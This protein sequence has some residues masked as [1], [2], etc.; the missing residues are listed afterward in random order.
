MRP[1][2]EIPAGNASQR[3]DPA[4]IARLDMVAIAYGTLLAD[5]TAAGPWPRPW[6]RAL[7]HHGHPQ[8]RWPMEEMESILATKEQRV[9][10]IEPEATVI[11]AVERMCAARV[12]ALLV[13]EGKA[14]LGIFSERDL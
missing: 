8:R 1:Q 6:A 7:L 11:E 13:M 9:H 3:S 5:A 12:G 14:L 10:V 4:E 2:A